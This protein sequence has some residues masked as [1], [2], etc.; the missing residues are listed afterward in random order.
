MLRI[1]LPLHF[2]EFLNIRRN[3]LKMIQYKIAARTRIVDHKAPPASHNKN[4]P[5]NATNTQ[6]NIITTGSP[7]PSSIKSIDVPSKL[8]VLGIFPI[9][10]FFVRSPKVSLSFQPLY[11]PKLITP[12]KIKERIVVETSVLR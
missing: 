4:E 1:I 9:S 6:S 11:K 5:K 8:E 2:G 10:I 7:H 12:K 3:A